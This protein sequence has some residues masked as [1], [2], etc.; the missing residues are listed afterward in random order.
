MGLYKTI[1][2][3]SLLIKIDKVRMKKIGLLRKVNIF[4]CTF[5]NPANSLNILLKTTFWSSWN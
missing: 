4:V 2:Q 3:R 1:I 5:P